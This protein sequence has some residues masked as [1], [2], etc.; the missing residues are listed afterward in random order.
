MMTNSIVGTLLEGGTINGYSSTYVNM[1]QYTLE[2]GAALIARECASELHDIF[3][4]AIVETNEA[5]L[6]AYMEGSKDVMESATYGPVFEEAEKKANNKILDFLKK[7]MDRV[8]A[9]FK[10]IGAKL[11]LLVNDYEKFYNKKK[12]DLKGKSLKECP[13]INWNVDKLNM[14]DTVIDGAANIIG[15]TA[16]KFINKINSAVKSGDDKAL[17]KFN[18]EVDEWYRGVCSTIGVTVNGNSVD[19]TKLNGDLEKEFRTGY[20]KLTVDASYVEAALTKAKDSAKKI[21]AA[22]KKFDKSYK[23]AI[24]S[25]K[26]VTDEME[27]KEKKG[28]TQYINK[29]VSTMSKVQ[30]V[31]NTY[32]SV[33][34]RCIIARANE[35]KSIV[36]HII[37]GKIMKD[38]DK[39]KDDNK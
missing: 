19:L 9:F 25:V 30:S 17:E 21:N 15:S 26:N 10:N 2:S 37:S 36:N 34:Y 7:L 33:G 22:T 23:D 20:T 35:A 4:V 8:I 38:K 16:T 1:P 24:K 18:E 27:R 28:Y 32:A 6:G 39:K 31:Y 5:V 11:S 3:E 14:V 13:V 29:V 12:E